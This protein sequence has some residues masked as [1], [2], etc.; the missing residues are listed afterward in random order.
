VL[1]DV[2]YPVASLTAAVAAVL[3]YSRNR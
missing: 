1:R 2:L 3:A